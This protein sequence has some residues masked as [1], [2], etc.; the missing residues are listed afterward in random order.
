MY[1]RIYAVYNPARERYLVLLLI[2]WP[3]SAYV[4]AILKW[5]DMRA[6]ITSHAYFNS[7]QKNEYKTS[8]VRERANKCNYKRI[9]SSLM[10]KI[11]SRTSLSFIYGYFE[12]LTI[13]SFLAET[14]LYIITL[15]NLNG[16][17]VIILYNRISFIYIQMTWVFQ[18]FNPKFNQI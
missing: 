4:C 2:C 16:M 18:N 11:R 1:S 9:I 3:R 15:T 7:A 10:I 13:D 14:L 6:W 12:H 5:H 8:A 17:C